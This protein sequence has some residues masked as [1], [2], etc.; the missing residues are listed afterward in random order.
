MCALIFIV[1]L[2]LLL[3]FLNLLACLWVSVAFTSVVI[4]FAF[5]ADLPALLF[6]YF[7]VTG[8]VVIMVVIVIAI[9][10]ISIFF[11]LLF[12]SVLSFFFFDV[13]SF[14]DIAAGPVILV[15]ILKFF[16][17][18]HYRYHHCYCFVL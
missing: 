13:A 9:I 12:H 3:L 6:V 11:P 8:F 5:F 1:V 2:L 18:N 4:S 7:I 15:R 10:V 14:S 17:S 16:F